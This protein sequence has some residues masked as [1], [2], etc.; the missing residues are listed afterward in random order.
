MDQSGAHRVTT[1][2]RKANVIPAVLAVGVGHPH[3][4][5]HLDAARLTKTAVRRCGNGLL[6]VVQDVFGDVVRRQGTLLSLREHRSRRPRHLL[7]PPSQTPPLVS[8]ISPG[9][10]SRHG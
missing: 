9:T 10:Q 8:P 1:A 7:G 5:Q 3:D 4:V 2:L 6:H